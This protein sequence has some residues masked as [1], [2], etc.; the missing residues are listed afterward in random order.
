MRVRVV[1]FATLSGCNLPLLTYHSQ[2]AAP[3]VAG[4]VAITVTDKREPELGGKDPR[5]VG[6]ERNGW[7]SPLPVRASTPTEAEETLRDLLGQAAL[8]AGIGVA[9]AT[10]PTPTAKVTVEIQRM[11]CDG[12]SPVYKADLTAN[13]TVLGA[14]GSVRMPAQELKSEDGSWSCHDAYRNMLTKTYTQAVAMMSQPPFKDAVV[15]A[16]HA[17]P[18][19]APLPEPVQQ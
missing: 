7:G 18:P 15:G 12:Y 14:D 9:K 2:P 6:Q 19:P 1:L 4:K 3:M 8:T 13:V 10:D 17:P 5:V 11:W 16:A